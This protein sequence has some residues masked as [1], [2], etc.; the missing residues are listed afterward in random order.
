MGEVADWHEAYRQHKEAQRTG[1]P[2]PVCGWKDGDGARTCFYSRELGAVT[3]Q[4]TDAGAMLTMTLEQRS[5]FQLRH[6]LLYI[7]AD[8]REKSI[9][10]V[11][12]ENRRR[13]APNLDAW[14][15]KYR[16]DQEALPLADAEPYSTWVQSPWWIPIPSAI[17]ADMPEELRGLTRVHDDR[18]WTAYMVHCHEPHPGCGGVQV[19]LGPYHVACSKC[20]VEVRM[21]EHGID[22]DVG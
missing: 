15:A 18:L 4:N 16:Q 20:G 2:C 17:P 5:L 19:S 6:C 21:W 12:W 3:H 14:M 7:N 22:Y 13:N 9:Q 11:E 1:G 8:L 10:R